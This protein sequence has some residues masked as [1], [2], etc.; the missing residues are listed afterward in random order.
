[1]GDVSGALVV[2]PVEGKADRK[3]FLDVA[4]R[5]N[6]D[7]P[8]WVPPLRSE[9]AEMLDPS[10]NPFFQHADHQFFLARRNGRVVGRISA[11]IDKL[12]LTMPVEQGMGPG[13]GMWGLFD[14]EDEAVAAPLIAAAEDWLRA[15]GMTRVLAPI[16]LSIWE[17]PGLLTKGHDHPPMVMMGHHPAKYQPWIEAQGYAPAKTLRTFDLDV[18]GGFPPLIQRIIT[19]GQKNAKIRIREVDKAKFDQEAALILDIL[20]DAWSTNW[21]FVPITDAEVAYTGKKLRPLVREDLIMVAE[22][23]GE[24]VAFMMTLPDVN[25]PIKVIGGKLFP[26]GWV[27]LLNW[28][29]K[30][31]NAAMRVPLMGVRKHLQSSRLA[32]QLAFMMIEKI[33][34][35][36]IRDYGTTRSEIGWILDDNQGMNAIAEAIDA[37]INREYTIY[38]KAL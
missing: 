38:G 15:K 31:T 30:P 21:G 14:A 10:K 37:D 4:Y 6:G 36:A 5:L 23:E 19:S 33:R 29:R 2:A 26:F 8:N 1:M 13:T 16:S 7:D 3:A 18:S 24:P 9:A 28:I 34:L 11:H 22:Y 27:R 12:A 17:E 25:Q 35:N 20:N 32:S